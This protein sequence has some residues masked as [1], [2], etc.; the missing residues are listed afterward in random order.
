[1]TLWVR[2]SG[3]PRN[4]AGEQAISKLGAS[5]FRLALIAVV[6]SG[7]V[8]TGCAM[9]GGMGSSD[10]MGPG[11]PM[12]GSGGNGAGSAQ[13]LPEATELTLVGD[14]FEFSPATITVDQG[15]PFN[16]TL[17]NTGSLVHDLTIAEFGFSI[18]AN[19]GESVTGG[20]VPDRPGTYEFV[21]S[22]PGH[23]QAGMSGTILVQ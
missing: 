12:M 15:E 17:I 23:A 20:F 4:W 7:G 19:P 5:R 1:M 22:I 10:H 16:L 18:V 14:E 2:P 21:C 8:I 13:P 11:S 9:P 3:G 6:A